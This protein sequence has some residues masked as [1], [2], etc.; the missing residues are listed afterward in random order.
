MMAYGGGGGLTTDNKENKNY[1]SS[2][3]G[4][5]NFLNICT[6]SLA[7]HAFLKLLKCVYWTQKVK[8]YDKICFFSWIKDYIENKMQI[9][10][11]EL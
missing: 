8:E 9:I 7:I 5:S 11:E 1:D 2:I 3:M 6:W 10:K 4:G